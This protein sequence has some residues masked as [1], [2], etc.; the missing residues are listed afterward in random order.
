[1]EEAVLTVRGMSCQGCV[2]NLTQLLAALV[3]VSQVEVSLTDAS[4]RVVYDPQLVS[5]ERLAAVIDDAGFE[6]D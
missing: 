5:L 3:G 1:M 2:R 6:T 4:A